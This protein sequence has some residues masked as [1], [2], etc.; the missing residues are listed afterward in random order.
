MIEIFTVLGSMAG[1]GGVV[2]LFKWLERREAR[3]VEMRKI[4]AAE[5][6]REDERIDNTARFLLGKTQE[7]L[8]K[9]RDI[10]ERERKA[11]M[12]ITD[13]LLEIEAE[14]RQLHI[15]HRAALRKL[16]EQSKLNELQRLKIAQLEA[17]I[18][19]MQMQLLNKY[20]D[21]TPSEPPRKVDM[22]E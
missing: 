9:E 21:E 16:D 5:D 15:D 1:A 11:R 18:A 19:Q 17:H 13:R 3:L 14:L 4:D 10:V 22:A 12:T 6:A 8:D 2:A 20:D 7:Q